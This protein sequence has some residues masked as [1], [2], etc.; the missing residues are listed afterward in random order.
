MLDGWQ[1]VLDGDPPPEV[2]AERTRLLERAAALVA[3]LKPQTWTRRGDAPSETP[4]PVDCTVE[5]SG[6]L[7]LYYLGVHSVASRCVRI[8]RYAGASSGAQAPF[9]QLLQGE[10]QTIDTHLAH[11]L[12]CDRAKLGLLRAIYYA[13]AHWK[14]L[15]GVL[16]A[17]SDKSQRLDG[18]MFVSVT[19]LHALRPRNR[20]FSAFP[21]A[22]LA[23]EV[24]Y[25]T[26][27]AWTT[28]DGRWATDGGVTN[29][30]PH[31]DDGARRAL[32]VRPMKAG[33][34]MRMAAQFS[35]ADGVAAIER[36][37]DDAARFFRGEPTAAIAWREAG[38]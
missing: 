28:C 26:G 22:Q 1:A 23:A 2:A 11:G 12:L 24:F 5:G 35:M 31:F 30:C 10:A 32:V 8:V 19:Q 9:Q 34:S 7:S 36:G 33:L 6:F 38:G 13:D 37:Q 20:I 18:K 15:A 14:A 25:A 3:D 27:T 16:S 4:E 17:R 21:T 29:G